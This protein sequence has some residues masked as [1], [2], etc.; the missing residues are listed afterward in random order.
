MKSMRRMNKRVQKGFTLIELMIVVAIVGILAA[1]ALP[2]YNN[3]MIKSKLTE[4]TTDLDAARA[5]LAEAYATN[6]QFP[7]ASPIA[8]LGS[9]AK[10]V[11]AQQYTQ[12]SNGSNVSVILTLGST[13]A[14]AIDGK[15]LGLWGQGMPDGTVK[16]VCGT[17][18]ANNSTA[19]AS[20]AAMY[21]YLPANCQ[22]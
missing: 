18:T 10:Y 8:P 22:N 2:A 16:W 12:Q 13:G 7:T 3:Y 1:I 5:A 19:A 4:A 20:Q 9:N 21:S 17:A 15:Y 14:A 11:T 6:G